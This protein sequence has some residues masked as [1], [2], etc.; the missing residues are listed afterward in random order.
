MSNCCSCCPSTP[1]Q[2]PPPPPDP[3][4]P[5]RCTRF[6]VTFSSIDVSAIDDG[7]LG[8][9]LETTWTFVVNG[10]V[11]ILQIDPLDVGVR[12]LG[13]TFF[14][15]VPTDSSSIVI[16]VSGVEDDPVFDDQLPGF[17]H[18][19]GLAQN[20]GQGAQFGSAS[21]SNITYR[22]NYLITCAQEVTVSIG[23]QTLSAYAQERAK[24]RKGVKD[25]TPATLLS[26][27]LDRLRR[28]NWDL[29]LATDREFVFK[30]YGTLPR[31]LEQKYEQRQPNKR[32]TKR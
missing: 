32:K 27:S 6:Q 18:V 22:M 1:T 31:L 19:W 13:V 11:Q 3:T 20:F 9:S 12:T 17:T 5:P 14:V 4:T 8:G 21:D 2:P 15:D 10:Q 25:P 23:R 16:Q 28:G 7:F 29:V 24:T 26:W 30:G